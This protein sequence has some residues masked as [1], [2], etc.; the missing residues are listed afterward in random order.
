MARELN[1]I[2]NSFYKFQINLQGKTVLTEAATGNFVCTP[3]LA[4]LAGASVFAIAKDSKYGSVDQ[5]QNEVLL[6]AEELKIKDRITII[7][8]LDNIDLG[9]IDVVTN[10]GFVRPINKFIIDK[11][12]PDCVIPLMWEPWEFR[13]GDLDLEFARKKGIKVYGTNESDIRLHTMQYIGLTCLYFML[14]E[15]RSPFSSKILV[16]GCDKFNRAIEIELKKLNY[17]VSCFLTSQYNAQDIQEYDTII[18]AEHVKPELIIGNSSSAKIRSSAL[19]EEQIIIHISGNV[20]FDS[21]LPCKHYPEIPAPFGYMSYS[22]DFI[23]PTAVFDLHAA[24][25]KVAEGMLHAN[26]KKLKG[27]RY[28]KFMESNFPS[29]AFEN[30]NYW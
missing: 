29:L 2:K 30:R 1:L 11:L 6:L 19:R 9:I 17:S 4:A 26:S 18:I 5:A 13:Q 14:K 24:G 25:L 3:I 16:I 8:S 21:D 10:T 23:D 12:K 27:G 15:K 22:T 28:K 7:H 20:N